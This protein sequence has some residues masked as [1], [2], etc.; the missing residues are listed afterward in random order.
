MRLFKNASNK[1]D[2]KNPLIEKNAEWPEETPSIRSYSQ[3]GE[4]ALI[5]HFFYLHTKIVN[6]VYVDIGAFDPVKLSNT[7][8]LHKH[9]WTGVNIDM[10]PERVDAF[11]RLRP[12]DH[13]ILAAVGDV[14]GEL[15]VF[16]CPE[17]PSATTVDMDR[18]KLAGYKPAGTV[19][20]RTLQSI[21]NE[22]GISRVDYVNIDV[23]GF[24]MNVLSSFDPRKYNVS[25]FTVEIIKKDIK[26]II[27]SDVYKYMTEYGY[28]FCGWTGWSV[29]F[30]SSNLAP[31]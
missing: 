23:E 6:G 15:Q 28:E 25:L 29:F 13:N 21:L 1:S 24:E 17:M 8:L 26:D 10:I 20:C 31:Y 11:R 2:R 12:Q 5:F 7:F 22:C 14:E 16:D 9:G 19:Q 18:G 30:R 4:D 27:E 3:Y